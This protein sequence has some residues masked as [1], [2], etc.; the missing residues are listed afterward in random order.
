MTFVS[1][2]KKPLSLAVSPVEVRCRFAPK[3]G[4]TEPQQRVHKWVRK[5]VHAVANSFRKTVNEVRE[6]SSFPVH[7]QTTVSVKNRQPKSGKDS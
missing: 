2:Q 3:S 1:V 6:L 5:K 7:Q 4:T